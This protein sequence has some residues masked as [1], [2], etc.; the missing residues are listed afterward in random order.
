MPHLLVRLLVGKGE[1]VF[2]VPVRSVSSI[3]CCRKTRDARNV[4]NQTS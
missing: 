2:G 4:E 1:C 3:E